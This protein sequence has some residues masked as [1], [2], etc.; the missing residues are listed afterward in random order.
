M[1]IKLIKIRNSFGVRLPKSLIIHYGLSKGIEIEPT[2]NGILLKAKRK[3]RA[4]W[5]Q[6]LAAAVEQGN[7]PDNVLL[8]GFTNEQAETGFFS[9]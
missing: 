5:Y 2:E 1:E 7:I 8:E 3:A 9:F 4:G 6:Q